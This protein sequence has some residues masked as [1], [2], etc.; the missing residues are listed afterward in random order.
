MNDE[1]IARRALLKAAVVGA[2][3]VS[4]T[5][6]SGKAGAADAALVPLTAADPTASALGYAEDTTKVDDKKYPLHKATQSCI[7]C[8][9]FKGKVGDARGSCNIYAGK[10]VNAHG[11]CSVWAQKPGA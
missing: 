6:L 10:S 2:V 8:V 5:G 3:A 9:Q 11:W 1:L 7:N 4:V